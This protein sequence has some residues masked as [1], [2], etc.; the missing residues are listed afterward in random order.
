MTV[1][2]PL[3]SLRW[4]CFEALE[5]VLYV[6]IRFRSPALPSQL[7]EVS[8]VKFQSRINDSAVLQLLRKVCFKN[9]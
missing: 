4:L 9:T 3:L 6:L 5:M 2:V 7:D 1:S 8:E